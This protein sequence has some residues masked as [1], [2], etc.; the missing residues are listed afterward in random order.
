MI[1]KNLLRH[2]GVTCYGICMGYGV[3][4]VTVILNLKAF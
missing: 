3:L 4:M 1:I 2:Y